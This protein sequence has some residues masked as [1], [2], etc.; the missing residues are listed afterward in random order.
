MFCSWSDLVACSK[1]LAHGTGEGK[2]MRRDSVVPRVTMNLVR[3]AHIHSLPTA[4]K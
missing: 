2:P 3:T 1:E 4:K